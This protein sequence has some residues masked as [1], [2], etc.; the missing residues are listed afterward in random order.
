[1]GVDGCGW[2]V[3][4]KHTLKRELSLFEEASIHERIREP[5]KVCR[6]NKCQGQSADS[7]QTGY[8]HSLSKDI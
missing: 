5:Q 3:G 7:V 2:G 8:S 6:P 1:M 4:A